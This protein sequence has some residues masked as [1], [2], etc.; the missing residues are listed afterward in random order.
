MANYSVK[1]GQKVYVCIDGSIF[2]SYK[3]LNV[4]PNDPLKRVVLET[5]TNLPVVEF[6]SRI[7]SEKQFSNLQK[8]WI[9]IIDLNEAG[10]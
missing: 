4:M 7:Y 1:P 8:K 10:A 5:N 9:N 6:L 2:K 3:V